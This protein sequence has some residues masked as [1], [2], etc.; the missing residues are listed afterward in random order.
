MLAPAAHA[1]IANAATDVRMLAPSFLVWTGLKAGPYVLLLKAGPYVLLQRRRLA[2]LRQRPH[3][4]RDVLHG[5]QVRPLRERSIPL[6]GGH[7]FVLARTI[8]L[9]DDVL[10][11]HQ[12]A[13]LGEI[14]V[15]RTVV[16]IPGLR[17]ATLLPDGDP[18]GPEPAPALHGREHDAVDERFHCRV[19]ERIFFG[20]ECVE[21]DR[22]SVDERARDDIGHAVID[23][24]SIY[25]IP[26]GRR[27]K[28]F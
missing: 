26:H 13:I 20:L 6:R 27:T 9:V 4:L 16:R 14:W 19:A 28:L 8:E 25:R 2:E 11:R 7:L 23:R 10:L 22:A 18:R 24:L 15:A 21:I 3:R 12:L 1:A 17:P 5:L